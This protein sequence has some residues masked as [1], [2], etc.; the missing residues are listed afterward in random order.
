[1]KRTGMLVVLSILF[2]W[3]VSPAKAG[4]STDEPEPLRIGKDNWKQVEGLV[5]DQMQVWLEQG[6]IQ[7]DVRKIDFSPWEYFPSYTKES[8]EKNAGMFELDEKNQVVAK[9]TGE[10]ARAVVGLPFPKIAP[11]DTRAA[12]KLMYN[13]QYLPYQLEAMIFT[14]NVSWIGGRGLER[15][16]E[17][18]YLDSYLTGWPGADKYDNPRGVERDSI[19]RVRKPYDLAGTAVMLWRYFSSKADMN[20]SYVPAIRRI[21]RTSPANRS[22]GFLGSDFCVDDIVGYDGKVPAFEWKL[23][24]KR[25][26]LIAMV[27]AQPLQVLPYGEKGWMISK[28]VKPLRYGYHEK[29]SGLALWWPLDVIFVKRPILVVE[30]KARDP[31]YNYGTQHIWLDA[32]TFVPAYKIVFDRSGEFWKIVMLDL[33]LF[34]SGDG[35]KRFLGI[36]D[37]VVVDVKREHATYLK[38]LDPSTEGV[39]FARIN[40]NEYTLAGFQK[41]CK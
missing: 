36:S 2:L 13:K 26:A 19:L 4:T 8:W 17:A 25:E 18:G 40:L 15:D 20:F 32:E 10:L 31:Y 16:V 9:G 21:R 39:Y 29:E 5:P 14:T 34:E 24:E 11:D 35:K 41:Y 37:H 28:D 1:M 23:L 33:V 7:L 22:D 6:C 12:T 3:L 30:G 27:S 38:L